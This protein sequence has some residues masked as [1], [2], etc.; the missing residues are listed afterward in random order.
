MA[1]YIESYKSSMDWGN[2]FIRTGNFPLDRSSIFDSYEDAV[3]Y[4]QGDG[5]DKRKLGKTSYI[6]QIITVYEND[7]VTVYKING[8]RELEEV[9]GNIND[10]FKEPSVIVTSNLDEI[11]T[12]LVG[13]LIYCTE[14]NNKGI[15]FVNEVSEIIKLISFDNDGKTIVIDGGTF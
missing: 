10:N 9:G 2:T 8:N 5:S 14:T 15:F 6:G 13:Q 4:A 7:I 1:S 11:D 3:K 12:N